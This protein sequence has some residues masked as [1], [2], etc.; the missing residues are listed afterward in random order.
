[1][2]TLTVVTGLKT[3][4]FSTVQY[5]L[6]KLGDVEFFFY[7]NYP[8]VQ[9]RTSI[10]LLYKD[11]LPLVAASSTSDVSYGFNLTYYGDNTFIRTLGG[12]RASLIEGPL[13]LLSSIRIVSDSD[14]FTLLRPL[15]FGS[16]FLKGDSPTEQTIDTTSQLTYEY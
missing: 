9:V 2:T 13:E 12:R 4:P 14:L 16:L 11:Y 7:T 5:S 3:L 6:G 8:F 15:G 10:N 1:M